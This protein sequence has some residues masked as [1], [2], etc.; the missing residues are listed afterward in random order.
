METQIDPAL[1]KPKYATVRLDWRLWE[2]KNLNIHRGVLEW[3][4]EDKLASVDDLAAQVR[5]GVRSEFKPSWWRGFGFGA[6]LRMQSATVDFANICNHVDTRNRDNSVWQW[7]IIQFD[8]DKI[9]LGVHT[10]MHGYLRPV[11]DSLLLN[12]KVAGYHCK[13]VDT[14]IDKL[15]KVL[16][17]LQKYSRV[18]K[19]IEFLLP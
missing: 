6:V 9:A 12:L 14:D 5:S 11:Y 19:G 4:I 15:I 17:E 7:A 18:L 8:D 16:M 1:L 10:W 2:K 3:C 13:S